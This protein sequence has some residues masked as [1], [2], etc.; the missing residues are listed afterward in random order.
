[1][2]TVKIRQAVYD[3]QSG[4]CLWCDKNLTWD[5]FHMHEVVS[6]GKG[7]KI[8]LDNSVGLCYDCH[9]NRA[10]GNRK[11]QFRGGKR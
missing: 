6:R 2:T 1:M 11:P 5:Q 8:S 9:L 4:M 7:G 3:R 10:H